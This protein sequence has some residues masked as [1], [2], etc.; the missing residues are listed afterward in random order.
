MLT[1]LYC[2]DRANLP[3]KERWEYVSF[4]TLVEKSKV[5]C[6]S[7]VEKLKT[8]ASETF[9]ISAIFLHSLSETQKFQGKLFRRKDV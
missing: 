8:V 9:D 7:K 4:L 3:V 6:F 5:Y 1:V 2:Q